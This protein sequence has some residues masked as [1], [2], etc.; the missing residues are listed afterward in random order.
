M[1]ALILH[2]THTP[3][4]MTT[5][6]TYQIICKKKKIDTLQ[7]GRCVHQRFSETLASLEMVSEYRKNNV[8]HIN[9]GQHFLQE[10]KRGHNYFIVNIDIEETLGQSLPT[11]LLNFGQDVDNVM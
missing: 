9:P 5:I 7:L 2:P 6:F 4:G 3:Y 1:H 8:L 10:I 11:V